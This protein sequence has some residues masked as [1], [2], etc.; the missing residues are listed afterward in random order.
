MHSHDLQITEN[1]HADA[2]SLRLHACFVVLVIQETFAH[3]GGCD[4]ILIHTARFDQRIQ[5]LNICC[6]QSEGFL[7]HSQHAI[8]YETARIG[9]IG[10][11][12]VK[13][14]SHTQNL[15]QVN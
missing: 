3:F 6:G 13:V 1:T 7:K 14:R 11:V 10:L 5:I 4:K 9:A 12:V 2:K 8:T 15:T